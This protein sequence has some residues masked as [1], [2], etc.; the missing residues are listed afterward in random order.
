LAAHLDTT[1]ASFDLEL[2]KLMEHVSR[3]ESELRDQS[4][5]KLELVKAE[6][7]KAKQEL[8]AYRAYQE[9]QCM[10]KYYEET[11]AKVKEENARYVDRMKANY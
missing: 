8:I 10:C 2:R 9:R 5:R 7:H 6:A 1:R 3:R 4:D 11:L